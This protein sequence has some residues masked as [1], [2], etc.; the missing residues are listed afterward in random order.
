L[1]ILSGVTTRLVRLWLDNWRDR[2]VAV[3]S[4]LSVDE[5]VT[6]LA[7]G[8]TR[9]AWSRPPTPSVI[10]VRGKVVREYVRLTVHSPGRRSWRLV[11]DGH[12]AA[13]P[14]GGSELTGTMGQHR[15]SRVFNALW[16]GT[17]ALTAIGFTVAALWQ[18][19]TGRWSAESAGPVA[20]SFALLCLGAALMTGGL[21]SG[22]RDERYLRAWLHKQLNTGSTADGGAATRG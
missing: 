13:S 11:L 18:L 1:P 2:P 5:A 17:V 6:R 22:A 8:L 9:S 21:S 19:V 15:A 4:P 7:A 20:I 3:Q 16:L 14:A 12:I 10:R